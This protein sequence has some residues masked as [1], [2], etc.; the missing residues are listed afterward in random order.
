MEYKK[1]Y[2]EAHSSYIKYKKNIDVCI[3]NRAIDV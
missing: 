3:I 1:L 2:D